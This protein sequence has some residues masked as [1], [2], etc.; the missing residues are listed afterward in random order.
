MAKIIGIHAI[1]HHPDVSGADQTLQPACFHLDTGNKCVVTPAMK[2]VGAE[3]RM[4]FMQMWKRRPTPE[5]MRAIQEDIESKLGLGAPR[6]IV[7]PTQASPEQIEETT[8]HFLSGR[9]SQ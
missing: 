7:G 3:V 4:A 5:E 1:P 6:T 8:A 2:A 9:K